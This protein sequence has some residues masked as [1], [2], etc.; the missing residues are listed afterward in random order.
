MKGKKIRHLNIG[1]LEDVVGKFIPYCDFRFHRGI[2]VGDYQSCENKQCAHYQ[3]Y[4]LQ[5]DS[6]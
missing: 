5:D 1:V 2:I 4:R 3:K 6:H